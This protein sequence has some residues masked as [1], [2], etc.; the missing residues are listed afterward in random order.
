MALKALIKNK[1]I[2]KNA[3]KWDTYLVRPC[4]TSPNKEKVVNQISQIQISQHKHKVFIYE[5][6][7][8]L[9]SWEH[10]SGGC[11]INPRGE[12]HT[13]ILES[14][15]RT[16]ILFLKCKTEC[17]SRMNCPDGDGWRVKSFFTEGK[18][19]I[20]RSDNCSIGT[21]EISWHTPGQ[22]FPFL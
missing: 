15:K 9:T 16:N 12:I 17:T 5:E 18:Q 21:F 1:K 19:E 3:T 7:C 4:R 14:T 2:K 11:C 13:I 22:L 10:C 8:L 20:R 6:K